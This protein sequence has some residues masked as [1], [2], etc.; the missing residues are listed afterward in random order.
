MAS[1]HKRRRS[2]EDTT[3]ATGARQLQYPLFIDSPAFSRLT[4]VSRSI[5]AGSPQSSR[6]N[7]DERL[8]I[9]LRKPA[10]HESPEDWATVAATNEA[11]I[12]AEVQELEEADLVNETI[13]AIDMS[14]RDRGTLGCAYYNARESKLC[15]M[16]D[17]K[18]ANLDIVATLLIHV[19]PT[20][21]VISSRADE[22]LEEH[23]LKEARGIDRGD[24]ASKSCA[25][26]YCNSEATQTRY[27][28]SISLNTCPRQT[29]PLIVR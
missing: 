27:M 14:M 22:K 2:N 16:E 12:E 29:F 6:L 24:S 10:R 23:L 8:S 21:V 13:L 9:P 3:F 4:S 1:T 5:P 18:M 17:I 28:A 25:L 15:L 11:E 7:G 26:C 20:V 19:E